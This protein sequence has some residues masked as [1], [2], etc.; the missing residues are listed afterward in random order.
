MDRKS[1]GAWGSALA[2]VPEPYREQIKQWALIL[3][4]L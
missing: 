3:L 4:F 2:S 1:V